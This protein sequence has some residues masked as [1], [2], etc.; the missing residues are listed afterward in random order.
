MT[1]NSEIISKN[2]EDVSKDVVQYIQYLENELETIRRNLREGKNTDG[3]VPLNSKEIFEGIDRIPKTVYMNTTYDI[4][5][6]VFSH[7]VHWAEIKHGV[8][9]K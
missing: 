4:V 2:L 9:K 1:T 6:S 8:R 7:G 5:F 3:S